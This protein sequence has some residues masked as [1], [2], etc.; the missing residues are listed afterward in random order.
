MDTKDTEQTHEKSPLCNTKIKSGAVK[1]RNWCFTLNNYTAKDIK[2]L[3]TDD[4]K[5]VFQEET[6]A[7]GTKHL[8][9]LIMYINARTFIHMK[10]LNSRCHWEP[11][12]N[13]T[14]S[15]RYC[16]KEDTRT[17]NI[18]TNIK[19]STTDTDTKQNF[20]QKIKPIEEL[21]NENVMK[22]LVEFSETDT[23]KNWL[24]DTSIRL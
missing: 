4:Y 13:K 18:F 6:G 23:F 19:I 17:G 8:Q 9:G 15:I 14:A 10:K 20:I 11:C 12:K 5:Y 21:R 2:D 24:K 3:C 1:N 22:M 16:S 7:N